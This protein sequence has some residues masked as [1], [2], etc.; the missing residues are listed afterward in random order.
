MSYILYNDTIICNFIVFIITTGT[1]LALTSTNS[2][3]AARG[4]L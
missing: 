2:T 3:T 4:H 1:K